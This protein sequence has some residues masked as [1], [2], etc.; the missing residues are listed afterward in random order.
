VQQERRE[1]LQRCLLLQLPIHTQGLHEVTAL[2]ASTAPSCMTSM[3]GLRMMC[4][5]VQLL[6]FSSFAGALLLTPLASG[7]HGWLLVAPTVRHRQLHWRRQQG[8]AQ[9]PRAM[10]RC[11]R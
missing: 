2:S 3:A 11:R 4:S 1:T 8:L 10:Q 7:C 5:D 6:S 9:W